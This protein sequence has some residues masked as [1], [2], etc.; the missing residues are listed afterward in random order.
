[1]KLSSGKTLGSKKVLNSKLEGYE[2]EIFLFIYYAIYLVR[3]D[4]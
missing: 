3:D 4:I 2:V 1:M